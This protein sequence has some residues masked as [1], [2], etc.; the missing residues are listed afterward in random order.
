MVPVPKWCQNLKEMM[1]D[2][3]NRSFI[4]EANWKWKL[5]VNSLK[6]T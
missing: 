4:A 6:Y 1:V 3:K 2:D 5:T